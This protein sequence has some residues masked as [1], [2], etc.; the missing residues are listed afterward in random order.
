VH[1]Y[2]HNVRVELT[3]FIE[4]K[5]QKEDYTMGYPIEN[6]FVIAV[7]SSALFDLTDSDQVSRENG[8]EEVLS[9]GFSLKYRS[10]KEERLKR[11][12]I[13]RNINQK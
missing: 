13:T 2:S 6:K 12:N 11:I 9:Q 3:E 10:C 8:E 1:Q 7:A 5:Y 4:R